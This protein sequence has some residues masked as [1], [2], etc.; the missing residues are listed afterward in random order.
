MEWKVEYYQ[1]EN[2]NIP[3]VEFLLELPPKL[4]AKA[5]R[6]IELLQEH[7]IY[8]QEPYVKSIKGDQYKGLFEL[9]IKLGSDASRIF[10]FTY[11]KDTF[12][13]LNGFLKK[14]NKTPKMELEK[15]NKYRADYEK[16]CENE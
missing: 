2:G 10:Y 5:Y 9:R 11:H 3:V 8:L 6:E 16:R 4:R 15:A 13:L 12:V 1:R 14:T 7:G